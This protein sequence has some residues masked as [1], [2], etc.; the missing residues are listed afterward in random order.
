MAPSAIEVAFSEKVSPEV[1]KEKLSTPATGEKESYFPTKPLGLPHPEYTT[2]KGVSPLI[3]VPSAGLQYPNYTPFKLPDLVEHLF[4]DK[5]IGSDPKKAALLGAAT[6]VKHLTP[7]I[8]TELVGLQLK[9]LSNVQ[10]DELARLVAERGVVFLRDQDL[11]VYDQVEFGAYFGELHI[12]Q[13]AGIIPDIPWVHPIHKDET[14]TQGRSH[15]I[16]HSDVTYE[17]QPPGLTLLRMD[18]LPKAGPD[19]YETGGDTIWASGYGIYESLSPTLRK[20]LETLEAKH[21]GLEQAEKA[22]RTSGCLRRNPIETIHPVV[23]THPVTGWKTLFVNENFTKEIVG[24]EKRFSDALLDSLNR[25]IAEAYEYQ[26]RWKW[27]E[28]AVAIWDNRATFHTGIF[29]YF[30]HLRHGLRVAPQAEKPYFDP[31]SKLRKDDKPN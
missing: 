3:S 15:Q 7:A 18:K 1:Q 5:A 20:I 9:D 19:G 4:T 2:P 31:N 10:K 28:N 30:P 21:S 11:D 29:D 6:E 16:W 17:I 23:R 13:M 25:T 8:G 12:H 27:T 24:L 26:V 22:L 14:A